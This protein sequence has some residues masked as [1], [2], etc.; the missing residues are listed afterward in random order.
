MQLL[1]QLLQASSLTPALS[2]NA[3]NGTVAL[4]EISIYDMHG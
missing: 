1:T 3:T 2:Q 4:S